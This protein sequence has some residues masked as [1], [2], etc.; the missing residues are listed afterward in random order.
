MTSSPLLCSW[1]T[2]MSLIALLPSVAFHFHCFIPSTASSSSYSCSSLPRRTMGNAVSSRHSCTRWYS[3]LVCVCTLCVCT[4]IGITEKIKKLIERANC[5]PF[6]PTASSAYLDPSSLS[7]LICPALL[8][9][10]RRSKPCRWLLL[11]QNFSRWAEVAAVN[12]NLNLSHVF[13]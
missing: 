3:L 11:T 6:L 9:N 5:F 8:S 4:S 7:S 10:Q 13:N 1:Q 12:L 2:I